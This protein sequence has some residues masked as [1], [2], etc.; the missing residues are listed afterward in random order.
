MGT[1]HLQRTIKRKQ[2]QIARTFKHM[3]DKINAGT[4][5]QELF[6]SNN[7]WRQR[8]RLPYWRY[9][10]RFRTGTGTAACPSF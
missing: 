6:K 1:Y 7:G 3:P 10:T 5:K 2:Y 9:M 4:I 8:N